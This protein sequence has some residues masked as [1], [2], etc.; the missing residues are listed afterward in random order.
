MSG[1]RGNSFCGRM[2][3]DLDRPLAS[4]QGWIKEIQETLKSFVQINPLSFTYVP[5]FLKTQGMCNGAVDDWPWLLEYVPDYL[6]T[7]KM[8]DDVVRRGPFSL[9]FVPDWFVTQ[10]QTKRWHD[11]CCPCHNHD[12][13]IKW[14][15]GYKKRKTQKA[16]KKEELMAT[17]WHPDHVKDWCMPEDEKR[18]WK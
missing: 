10:Q 18:C 12:R 1:L 5:D 14:Y 2:I 6:K 4:A 13:L 11:Y 9:Q 16:S 3:E 8:F 17:G 15:E 7:Q